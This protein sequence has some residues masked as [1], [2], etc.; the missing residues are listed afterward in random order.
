MNIHMLLHD[1]FF[2]LILC[3]CTY[4]LVSGKY[5]AEY[6]YA[7]ASATCISLSLCSMCIVVCGIIQIHDI[8][9]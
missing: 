6:M 8:V 5:I 2:T 3:P 4:A 9:R 7:Y 1:P